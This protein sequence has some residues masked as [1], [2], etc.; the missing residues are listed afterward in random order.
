MC[1]QWIWLANNDAAVTHKAKWW[2]NKKT[3]SKHY[4]ERAHNNTI[5][6][7]CW[8]KHD[9]RKIHNRFEV[10]RQWR[11]TWTFLIYR[12]Y[13]ALAI[14]ANWLILVQV[15]VLKRRIAIIKNKMF[16]GFKICRFVRSFVI[17]LSILDVISVNVYYHKRCTKVLSSHN[18]KPKS[19]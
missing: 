3:S 7:S 11:K 1:Y 5:L 9:F 15:E 13:I 14:I 2:K 19:R 6:S 16:T 8:G 17:I 10:W 4:G 12:T 18:N